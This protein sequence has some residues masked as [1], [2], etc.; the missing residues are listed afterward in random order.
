MLSLQGG[1]EAGGGLCCSKYL[2]RE[3]RENRGH[4]T[5]G[6]KTSTDPGGKVNAGEWWISGSGLSS[7]LERTRLF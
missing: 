1:Q 3:Q 7:T 2:P 6:K 5:C 4:L